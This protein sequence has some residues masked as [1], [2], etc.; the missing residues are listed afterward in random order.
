MFERKI[1]KHYLNL[2]KI[3]YG[4][5]FFLQLKDYT[6]KEVSLNQNSKIKKVTD[7]LL[8]KKQEN[9]EFYSYKNT[10]SGFCGCLFENNNKKELVLAYRGT[11]RPGLGENESDVNVF[12]KD[13][14]TDSS[15]L[16]GVCAEQFKDAWEFY[17][18]VRD[19]YPKRKIVIVGHSLGGA[20]A[21]I[22]AAKE[23]TIN[24][25]KVET[26]TFNAPGCLHL[27]DLY[28]CNTKFDYSF[29][30]N[31][32]VMNDWC[33]MFGEHIGVRYLIAPIELNE[34]NPDSTSEVLNNILLTTHEG[35]FEYSEEKMGKV[36]RK[37]REFGQKEGLSLWYYDSKNPLKDYNNVSE[38]MGTAST[39]PNLPPEI[40]NSSF[41][42]KAEALR[43]SIAE[44]VQNSEF[45][46]A[47]KNATDMIQS[48][49]EN[50]YNSTAIGI[51]LNNLDMIMAE[52]SPEAL[53]KAK[54]IVKKHFKKDLF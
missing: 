23:Y 7:I 22:I 26:Y 51:A 19:Q 50:W 13:L 18:A 15:F 27:L 25:K 21:Q 37:P 14:D 12:M 34:V 42:Q 46:L 24:R 32:S 30:T 35:V 20:L 45:G 4:G 48:Q 47:I 53:E 38:L 3:V 8:S 28:D 36:I 52:L 41:F 39:Q 49:S 40:V 33:G 17:K 2:S 6:L 43:K 1:K 11:E 54:K 44:N 5:E 16:V 31:Y 9:C 29:I 10:D